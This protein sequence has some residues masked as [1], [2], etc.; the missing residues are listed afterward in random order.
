MHSDAPKPD[1]ATPSAR[2]APSLWCCLWRAVLLRCP[3]CGVSP[4][5]LPVRR[6]R[7]FHDWFTPLPGCPRCGYAYERESGY[8][9]M[10]TWGSNY[11]VVAGLGIVLGLILQHFMA[12][13]W[14][15]VWITC[16][17][18]LI[19]G[20]LFARHAKAIYLAIDHYFDPHV[21]PA[22]GAEKQR[23]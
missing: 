8:F 10:A 3:E 14:T 21:K 12:N 5:Y 15:V 1:Y 22:A 9:L 7:R 4:L 20:F 16:L 19:A 11:F 17:A 6:T 13:L 23:G 18:T 2:R